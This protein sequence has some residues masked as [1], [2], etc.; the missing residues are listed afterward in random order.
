MQEQYL[1]PTKIKQN[2]WKQG[3]CL[4]V[5]SQRAV[6]VETL[7]MRQ[8]LPAGLYVI[9]SQDC[10]LLQRSLSKEPVVELICANSI[11]TCSPD[12]ERGK[13]PRQ[14]HLHAE[15]VG[16]LE[17]FPHKRFL[18]PR[19]QLEELSAEPYVIM[20][21]EL[22]TLVDWIAKRYIRPG[23]PDAFNLRVRPINKK[24]QRIV[25]RHIKSVLGLFV[26]VLPDVEVEE[27]QSYKIRVVLLTHEDFDDDEAEQ[28]KLDKSFDDILTLLDQTEGV[29]VD[30]AEGI[31]GVRSA[32]KMYY[33]EVKSLRKWDFDFLSLLG[34]EAN[35]TA[36]TT[37][38]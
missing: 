27:N 2:G 1:D 31:T 11:E 25:N 15:K 5:S 19:I 8:E 36:N 12:K 10:D 4:L 37:L 7:S 34:D 30:L 23:F 6:F 33:V 24:L 38:L 28:K 26:R 22:K 14:L 17:F 32:T 3:A 16:N 9:L 35:E 21:K 13:N 18:M 20:G 29:E